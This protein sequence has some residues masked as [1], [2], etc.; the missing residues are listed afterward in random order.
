MVS[1]LALSFHPAFVPPKSG[2]ELR[3]FNIYN[4]LSTKHKVTLIS[5]TYPNTQNKVEY[6]QHGRNFKEIRIPK[7]WIS[8]TLHYLVNKLSD[9]KECSAIITS[10]E[11]RFNQNFRTLVENEIRESDAVIFISPYLSTIGGALLSKKIIIYEAYNLEHELME[12]SLKSS[13]IGTI[14]LAYLY[15]LEK[16]LSEESR[17]IIAVSEENK[18]KFH[19]YYGIDPL[20]IRVSP[21]GV[22]PED[23]DDLTNRITKSHPIGLFLGSFHPPNIEAVEAIAGFAGRLPEVRFLIAGGVSRYFIEKSD[24]TEFM[25]ISN[26][27]IS[28][29]KILAK[30]IYGLEQW[31]SSE[32]VWSKK[33]FSL[34]VQSGINEVELK[35]YSPYTQK[36]M[37]ELDGQRTFELE[38]GWNSV[39]FSI[40]S[41]S[42]C[43]MLLESEKSLS[44]ERGQLGL[45]IQEIAYYEDGCRLQ[46]DLH[47]ISRK[48]FAFRNAMNVVLLGEVTDEEKRYLYMAADVALNPMMSGS[49]T[50]VKML[51][52][53]AARIPVVTTPV[54]ARGLAVEDHKDVMIC[55]IQDFPSKISE[56]LTDKSLCERLSLNGRR[57][58]EEQY[59]WRKIAQTMAEDL[60]E[61][62]G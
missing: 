35:L 5:F 19:K 13:W 48:A 44:D 3:L 21:N 9:I 56:L 32:I 53:M 33:E 15:H 8:K 40:H 4:H 37:V 12:S 27:W 38:E 2:G 26:S 45:A 39:S 16:K 17:I 24:L 55:A 43:T 52:Y 62:V 11:S 6:I 25:D 36:L 49:G 29:N 51:D 41:A 28:K 47:Q 60:E 14:F 59:D 30:G 7:T 22:N 34:C 23:Y 18:D 58:V 31:D 10:L 20:K 61:L 57:L 1:V 54:G 42:R 46:V 50:N